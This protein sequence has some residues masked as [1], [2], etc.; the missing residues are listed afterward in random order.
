MNYKLT[1][2]NIIV[3]NEDYIQAKHPDAIPLV[4]HNSGE[5]VSTILT[6]L[7][8]RNR[9]TTQE[10]IQTELA[11]LDDPSAALEERAN[12]AALRVYLADLD[13]AEFI[14]LNDPKI[15]DGIAMMVQLGLLSEDR[16]NEI[17]GV[18]N[19]N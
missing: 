19:Q 16:A 8:F 18:Q 9:F 1:C 2:G 7:E 11:S 17:L 3:A 14:D 13:A 12:R 15:T 10:K 5:L 4:E 6:K